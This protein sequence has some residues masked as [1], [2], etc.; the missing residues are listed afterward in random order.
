MNFWVMISALML[1]MLTG[2]LFRPYTGWIT[3]IHVSAARS[4]AAKKY[5]TSV[6]C[7]RIV[8]IAGL[9]LIWIA[10]D[11]TIM[12]LEYQS[13]IYSYIIYGLIVYFCTGCGQVAG[14]IRKF[15]GNTGNDS[16]IRQLLGYMLVPNA[17]KLDKNRFKKDFTNASVRLIAERIIMPF[18]I[19]MFLGAGAVTAYAF[20]NHFAHSDSH[21]DVESHG[22]ALTAIKLNNVISW[23]GYA[24]LS[25]LLW[26][27]KW[28]FGMKFS[29]KNVKFRQRCAM[30]IAAL[31]NDEKLTDNY[32]KT[33]NANTYMCAVLL[34]LLL[35]SVYVFIQTAL[36]ALGLDEYWD[37][38]NGSNINN[39]Q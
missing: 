1:N 2:W 7:G 13:K 29:F 4:L 21:D 36:A 30:Q 19:L 27:I 39:E 32:V 10:V 38:W 35:I 17:E 16:F 28:V 8:A 14:I 3:R 31:A 5:K 24:V 6:M 23:L 12:L 37:F 26:A 34:L 15:K 18:I 25:L 11:Y 33:L 22:Y 9:V 20:I